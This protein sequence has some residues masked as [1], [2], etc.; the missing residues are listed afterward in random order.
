[1]GNIQVN[2][3][4]IWTSGSEPEVVKR[5]VYVQKHN[6]QRPITIAHLEPS[7]KKFILKKQQMTKTCKITQHA[8]L[9][10]NQATCL[11]Y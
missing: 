5:K 6:G 1:M 4:E 8:E 9:K 2:L 11:V 3:Y 10:A 7:A